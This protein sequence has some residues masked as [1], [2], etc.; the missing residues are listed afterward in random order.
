MG[1]ADDEIFR[2][3][4]PLLREAFPDA[5]IQAIGPDTTTDDLP[6]WDSVAH[7]TLI[8]NIEDAFGITFTPE[9]IT[10]F[11]NVGDLTAL[12][13]RKLRDAS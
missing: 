6:D 5:D 7:V 13:A 10:Q 2:R 8:V 3:L 1:E 12:I 9:E 11:S 4:Q